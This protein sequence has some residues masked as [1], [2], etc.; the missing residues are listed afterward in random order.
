MELGFNTTV[1][2]LRIATRNTWFRDNTKF[3]HPNVYIVNGIKAKPEIFELF[4]QA[5]TSISD[6]AL[7][8]LDHV[9][10]DMV[11]N[12][13]VTNTIP[14]LKQAFEDEDVPTDSKQSQLLSHDTAQ[15]PSRQLMWL[16]G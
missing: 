14:P 12:V 2:P 11:H 10:I 7:S 1:D 13:I 4:L 16:S 15:P 6:F 8:H 9:T 3:H 5:A